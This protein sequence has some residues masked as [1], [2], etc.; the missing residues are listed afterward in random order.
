VRRTP[1]YPKSSFKGKLLST[2]WLSILIVLFICSGGLAARLHSKPDDAWI[3]TNAGTRQDNTAVGKDN[4]FTPY[5]GPGITANYLAS[6]D[7]LEPAFSGIGL[8]YAIQPYRNFGLIYKRNYWQIHALD[9]ASPY[10]PFSTL[11]TPV[12]IFMLRLSKEYGKLT[13]FLQF[14]S[15]GATKRIAD[16]GWAGPIFGLG[17]YLSQYR[18]FQAAITL[19][20]KIMGF[21]GVDGDLYDLNTELS[22]EITYAI[23]SGDQ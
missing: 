17:V 23:Q 10:T 2:C 14:G 4:V 21:F 20:R 18:N 8:V 13:P 6:S 19:E 12:N 1:R 22:F 7:R 3:L 16:H 5:Q 15:A 11:K 9:A